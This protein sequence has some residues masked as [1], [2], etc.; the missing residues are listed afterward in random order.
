[1][2]FTRWVAQ[3]TGFYGVVVNLIP[4][5]RVTESRICALRCG[6]PLPP[7]PKPIPINVT[8]TTVQSSQHASRH[9]RCT[10]NNAF[11][12]AETATYTGQH[13]SASIIHPCSGVGVVRFNSHAPRR[14]ARTAS[15]PIVRA[16]IHP[17]VENRTMVGGASGLRAAT[18][19]RPIDRRPVPSSQHSSIHPGLPVN[20]AVA[21]A[22]TALHNRQ[23]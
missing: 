13:S 17:A 23:C 6:S 21:H 7:P 15:Q 22:A 4:T 10:I 18:K 19:C 5:R 12:H 14:V 20:H 1:L 11:A 2:Y 8:V 3:L 9:R 16:M